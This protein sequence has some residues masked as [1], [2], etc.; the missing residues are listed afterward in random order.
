MPTWFG[1]YFHYGVYIDHDG[2]FG[3]QNEMRLF[4]SERDAMRCAKSMLYNSK[5]VR[6]YSLTGLDMTNQLRA[7]QLYG[8]DMKKRLKKVK[9]S[10]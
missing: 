3:Q 7:K 6:V 9:E 4:Q 10:A 5:E 2:K 8:T 1:N